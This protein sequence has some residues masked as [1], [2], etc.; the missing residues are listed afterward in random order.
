MCRRLSLA[1]ALVH[2]PQIVFSDGL[3][4]GEQAVSDAMVLRTL[5]DYAKETGATVLLCTD[6]L[7]SAEEI[8]G[9]VLQRLKTVLASPDF[10]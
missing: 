10:A 8:C 4:G 7:E 2:R 5:S 1:R 9:T 6:H 3:P